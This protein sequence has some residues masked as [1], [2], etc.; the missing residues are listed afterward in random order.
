MPNAIDMLYAQ[1]FPNG[2]TPADTSRYFAPAQSGMEAPASPLA[3]ALQ[4]GQ[5]Q[6]QGNTG[7]LTDTRLYVVDPKTG[8]VNTGLNDGS[9]P[10]QFNSVE[11]MR[12]W[13]RDNGE[14]ADMEFDTPEEA[15]QAVRQYT[16]NQSYNGYYE[17]YQ[18]PALQNG[19]PAA[20]GVP[21]ADW[22]AT[23]N[24]GAGA[25]NKGTPEGRVPP[26]ATLPQPTPNAP[27]A[28]GGFGPNYTDNGYFGNQ[29]ATVAPLPNDLQDMLRQLIQYSQD[30]VAQGKQALTGITS[31]YKDQLAFQRAGAQQTYDRQNYLTNLLLGLDASGHIG[32][33]GYTPG[34]LGAGIS[35]AIGT[36]NDATGLSPEAMAA[37]RLQAIEGP[38]SAYQGQVSQLKTQLASRGAFG[39]GETPGDLGAIVG[40]YAPLMQ[41]RDSTRSNLLSQAILANEQRKFDTLG[42]NRQTAANAMG[43]AAGLTTGLGNVFNPSTWLNTGQSSLAGLSGIASQIPAIGFTGINTAGGLANTLSD[44][45]GT[46]F[47][48]LLKASL[49][50]AAGQAAAG[51]DWGKLL[52]GLF[53]G[54]GQPTEGVISADGG[55]IPI[56]NIPQLPLPTGNPWPSSGNGFTGQDFYRNV[57]GL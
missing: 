26:S 23:Q 36:M 8:K 16:G 31:D 28:N 54:G 12:Q 29:S 21:F 44:Q 15:I 27:P 50:G 13:M 39:G 9:D 11:E 38:E 32:Q 22:N 48:N 52:G 10:R 35:S 42:L 17:G 4:Y 33:G 14:T 41:N 7:V 30:Q 51:V 3:Q 1:R 55:T 53:N 46:S 47:M 37:L 34:S 57:F 40:G 20:R 2:W 5:N 45:T 19:S 6:E 18:P 43:T 24:R 25:N 56:P 49:A